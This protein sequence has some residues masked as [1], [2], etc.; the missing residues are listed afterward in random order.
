MLCVVC[1]S[2]AHAV[3]IQVL[4]YLFRIH[5]RQIVVTWGTKYLDISRPPVAQRKNQRS[6][7]AR[8]M[9]SIKSSSLRSFTRHKWAFEIQGSSKNKS[10][11]IVILSPDTNMHSPDFV[12]RKVD[13]DRELYSVSWNH[14][15]C[16]EGGCRIKHA[17]SLRKIPSRTSPEI[18]AMRQNFTWRSWSYSPPSEAVY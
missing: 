16:C 9:Y 3:Y 15:E 10:Q 7:I 11:V 5:W 18:A 13:S 6:I 14:I 8:G 12:L 4:E 17:T 1:L 2:Q